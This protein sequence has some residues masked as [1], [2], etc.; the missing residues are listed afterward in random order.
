VDEFLDWFR[1]PIR[2]RHTTHPDCI[3]YV[4]TAAEV[5]ELPLD[6][7]PEEVRRLLMVDPDGD[8]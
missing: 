2:C 8:G 6:S 4:D 5:H 1:K 7:D 3:L